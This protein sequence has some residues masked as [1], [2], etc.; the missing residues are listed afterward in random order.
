MDARG[1]HDVVLAGAAQLVVCS[2]RLLHG[3]PAVGILEEEHATL[4][5]AGALSDGYRRLDN[6]LHVPV[7]PPLLPSA[8]ACCCCLAGPPL[9]VEPLELV[10]DGLGIILGHILLLLVAAAVF[11]LLAVHG[12]AECKAVKHDPLDG[13]PVVRVIVPGPSLG[14][15]LRVR[16][17]GLQAAGGGDPVRPPK[18]H[19]GVR[20]RRHG[21]VL[22]HGLRHRAALQD[23]V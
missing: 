20:H 7:L 9:Q 3:D 23:A 22:P 13:C 14:Q 1:I 5:R 6:V 21:K 8:A 4:I 2:M 17:R 15:V 12:V 18:I 10:L 16:E 19:L 11:L